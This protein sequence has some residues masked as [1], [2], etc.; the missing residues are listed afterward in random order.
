MQVAMPEFDGRIIGPPFCF[1]EEVDGTPRY[2]PDPERCAAVARLAVAQSRLRHKPNAEKRLAI[3]L[4]SYPT[5][6]ARVGNA[7]GLDTPASAL[8]LLRR[9]RDEGYHV[10]ELPAD[11]DE[12]IH[13]LIE[14]GAYDRD[15]LT[16]AQ[17]RAAPAGVTVGE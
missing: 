1:K 11:G 9:L 3:V 5:K 10:G 13:S 12:L 4:S 6:N 14:A 15:Y 7:V 2:V 17:M 8:A 16:S